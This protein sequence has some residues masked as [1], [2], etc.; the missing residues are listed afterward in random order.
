MARDVGDWLNLVSGDGWQWYVKYL[1]GNDTLL[2]RAHQAGPYVPRSIAFDVFPSIHDPNKENP[3]AN[4]RALIDSHGVEASPSLIWYNN[5]LRDGTR[6]ECHFTGWGGKSSPLL[7]PE[8]T[9]SL[10]VFAF[11]RV[12]GRDAEVCRIWIC[13]NIDEEEA[14]LDR[15]GPV[16]PG[17][18]IVYQAGIHLGVDHH[19]AEER[20]SPCAM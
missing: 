16:E 11:Y 5:K 6:D 9:G 14:V 20:D 3:L 10:V 17:Q 18:G 15:V 1:A 13:G 19:P 12:D 8:S 4:V 2:T 7:D